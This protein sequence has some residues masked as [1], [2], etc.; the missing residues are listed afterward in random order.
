MKTDKDNQHFL[1]INK[2]PF[3]S[4]GKLKRRHMMH[5]SSPIYKISFCDFEKDCNLCVI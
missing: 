3:K 2:C 4:L 5:N 1:T